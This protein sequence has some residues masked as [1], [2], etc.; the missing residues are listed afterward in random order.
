MNSIDDLK[1]L[2]S[3]GNNAPLKN[4]K[5]LEGIIHTKS[6]NTLHI[7]QRNFKTELIIIGL[8]IPI[9]LYKVI[10][11][12]HTSIWISFGVFVIGMSLFSY[13]IW[14]LYQ[15]NTIGINLVS[16][17]E[18]TIKNSKSA[19]QLYGYFNLFAGLSGTALVYTIGRIKYLRNPNASN[20]LAFFEKQEWYVSTFIFIGIILFC[21]YIAKKFS[22]LLYA[23]NLKKLE[24][25]LHD[26]NTLKES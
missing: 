13:S 9:I 17:L 3:K 6:K 11:L 14:K 23:E 21:I 20:I 19:I 4:I 7:I 12:N 10:L 22:D 24:E 16:D 15:R 18:N 26:L 25:N 2:W 8:F 1:D 5:E